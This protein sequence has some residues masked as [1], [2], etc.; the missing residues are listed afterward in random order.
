MRRVERF[1]AQVLMLLLVTGCVGPDGGMRRDKADAFSMRSDGRT[2]AAKGRDRI[3]ADMLFLDGFAE[4]MST[5][6]LEASVLARRSG[7]QD[8]L[9]QEDLERYAYLLFRFQ[10]CRNG[11][12]EIADAY[13]HAPSLFRSDSQRLKAQL[14][15]LRTMMQLSYS[16][17]QFLL[18]FYDNDASRAALNRAYP[19]A[20]MEAG[21]YNAILETVL[22]PVNLDARDA[23]WHFFEKESGPRGAIGKAAATDAEVRALAEAIRRYHTFGEESIS[24]LLGRR[25]IVF[26]AF[27]NRVRKSVAAG[28]LKAAG[29]AGLGGVKALGHFASQALKPLARSPFATPTDFSRE[30]RDL[31]RTLIKPGDILLTYSSGYLSSLFFP[32]VFKHGIVYV[33][34][35][36][37][38]E[39]LRIERA[40]RLAP[41]RHDLIEAVGSGV[42][43]N[44]LDRIVGDKVTLVAVLRPI[45]TMEQRRTYLQGVYDFIGRP[46]DLRFDFI[47]AK[48]LCCTEVI[49]HTLNGLGTIQFPMVQRFGMPTL[50]A[51]DILKYH[52]ADQGKAFELVFLGAPDPSSG[53]N[54]GSVMVG[55]EA[56][57]RLRVLL[58][59][60]R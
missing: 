14:L 7:G 19:L 49:Y 15:A 16:D 5:V 28:V 25:G 57:S 38:R 20:E 40:W 10:L 42:I 24:R 34:D 43:W 22:D 35:E 11:L 26:P 30:Q 1:F 56:D 2:G 59:A 47:C 53:G 6:L 60:G 44:D 27:E 37:Q 58:D 8:R 33:G 50:S 18:T 48:R 9:T 23:A 45:L 31:M 55:A 3:E 29:E 32:G 39:T 4:E 13:R 51:D 46:Y 52:L 41:R 54:A 12:W 36:L 21:T 17:S